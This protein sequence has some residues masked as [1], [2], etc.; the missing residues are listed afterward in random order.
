MEQIKLKTV[1]VMGLGYIGLP[2]ACM[3][4]S[5]GY[6]VH[7]VD[8]NKDI[9]NKLNSGIP[10]IE[11]PEL[12]GLFSK[13]FL[14]ERLE[15]SGKVKKADIYIISVPTPLGNENRAELK[16]VENAVDMIKE[17]ICSGNLVILESTSPPGTTENLV[18]KKIDQYSGLTAGKDY[19]LAFCPERV[20]P[21]RLIYELVNNDRVIGGINPESAE[22]ARD[23]YKSFSK[24]NFYLT[25]LKTAEIVKL[26]ENTYRD[27]NIA[28][29][30]ELSKICKNHRISIWDVIEIANK[31]PRV[32]IL[33][34][35]PGVGGHCIPI[36]PW[37]ILEGGGLKDTLIE[38]SRRVN[39]AMPEKVFEAAMDIL[40]DIKDPKITVLGASYK[41][42][43]DDTRESPTGAL[44]EILKINGI[45]ASVHD[46]VAGSFK[47]GLE[48]LE[49][50]VERSDLLLLMVGHNIFNELEFG[51]IAG[52]MNNRNIL[53]TRNFFPK[54]ELEKHSFK[55]FQL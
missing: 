2:T 18:G 13:V 26:A 53:D 49:P 38:K 7:G 22:K 6:S 25:D 19:L 21:G 28:F 37:F 23:L 46:P 55:Y 48:E 12:E 4:A 11:E 32:D 44:M 41:E 5:N 29:S 34:P 50:A 33:N 24:A 43:V 35:G 40:K 17:Y 9:I 47:Y 15:I 52:L 8:V 42:N 27:V 10:H 30:N 16:Y 54:K 14:K 31:H 1:C 20:L 51:N 45:N 36:D 39:D 3:L